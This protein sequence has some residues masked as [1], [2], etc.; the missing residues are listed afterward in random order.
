MSSFS[1]GKLEDIKYLYENVVS[2]NQEVLSEGG[3]DFDSSRNAATN[4]KAGAQFGSQLSDII[5]AGLQ[6]A[7]YFGTRTTSKNPVAQGVNYITRSY[8]EPSR[9][10]GQFGLGMLGINPPTPKEAG[11]RGTSTGGRRPGTPAT[12]SSTARTAPTPATSSPTARTAPA[13]STVLAKQRG[14]EG[15]LDK[16]T[17]KFTAGAFSDAEKSRYSSV[18]ARPGTQAAGPAS[19]RPK[20]QNP[21]LKDNELARMRAA[22]LM[23]QQNRNLPSGKIPTSSDL[24]APTPTPTSNATGDERTPWADTRGKSA[25][26]VTPLTSNQATAATTR[27]VSPEVKATNTLASSPSPITPNPSRATGSKKPGS[28]YENVEIN[29]FDMVLEYLMNT[30]HADSIHEA[31]YIMANLDSEMIE[32][33][34]E[35]KYVTKKGRNEIAMKI[36]ANKQN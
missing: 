9:Q 22:S 27:P 1:S 30:G 13:S 23:R 17:G 15:K 4:R 12:P 11:I 25:T 28:T 21:L 16:A 29:V 35:V 33:I 3:F 20:T 10:I 5:G 14:V 26:G 6:G 32:N 36:R 19:I 7:D 31:E 24:K 18:A 34:V 2:N 8:T